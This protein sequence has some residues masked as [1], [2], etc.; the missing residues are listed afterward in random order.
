M[1]ASKTSNKKQKKTDNSTPAMSTPACNGNESGTATDPENTEGEE[2]PMGRNKAKQQM[3]ERLDQSRKE[4]LDY[5]LD[6]K[7]EANTEKER[8]KEERYKIAFALDQQRI[9]L[10]KDKFEVK[11]MIE[12]DRL[13]RIDTSEM[14]LEEKDSYENVKK[15]ILS[16]WSAQA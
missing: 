7:K 12:E 6:K 16:R 8:K 4:S 14:S 11:R 10:E 3:R 2:R 9:G 15:K 1:A 5:L 13:M